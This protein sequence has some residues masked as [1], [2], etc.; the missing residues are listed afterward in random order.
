MTAIVIPR[1]LNDP[2][3]F[4]PSTLRNTSQP[5]RSDR[6]GAGSSGV[7][8][9]PQRDDLPAGLDRHPV[10]VGL[11]H[12]GPRPGCPH[13]MVRGHHVPTSGAVRPRSSTRSTLSTPRTASS[14]LSTSTVAASAASGAACVTTTSRASPSPLAPSAGLAHRRDAHVVAGEL[15]RDGRE[16]ARAVGD[17]QAHV[18][19]G[20]HR[21]HR[22][23]RQ[24]RVRRLPRPAPAD[25]PVAGHR[26]EVAEHRARRR[27]AARALAVEHQLPGRLGLDEHRVE[28][29]VDR[30][31]RVPGAGSSPGRPAPTRSPGRPVGRGPL[32][33]RQQLDHAAEPGGGGD[34]GGADVA[35]ALAVHV[36]RWSRG[37]GRPARRGSRPWTRRRSRRRPRSG[38]PRRSPAGWPP[39]ARRRSSRPRPPSPRG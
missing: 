23:H 15:A 20:R 38:R 4:A 29:P 27:R 8:P 12:P 6:C 24:V 36:R 10:P 26:D 21:A 1:S 33:D 30:G 22:P 32:A 37:C 16:H 7:P 5:A 2:V 9:S 34:V 35:D 19:A 18:V 14:P 31:Q 25:H 17:V 39:P 28:R 11:D 13:R 3:G